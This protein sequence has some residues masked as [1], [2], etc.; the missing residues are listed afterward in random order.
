MTIV[1]ALVT[2]DRVGIISDSSVTLEGRCIGETSKTIALPA[3]RAL[4]AGAGSQWVLS[5]MMSHLLEP[6]P[7]GAD[8]GTVARVASGALRK[9]LP[10]MAGA[11]RTLAIVG[12]FFDGK[13]AAVLLRAPNFDPE[14]LR[15]GVLPIPDPNAAPADTPAAEPAVKPAAA[16]AESAPLAAPVPRFPWRHSWADTLTIALRFVDWQREAR[17]VPTGGPL[18]LVTIAHDGGIELRRLAVLDYLEAAS[19]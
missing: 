10:H 7:S 18:E 6:L 4:V 2:P 14:S 13:L 15:F 3:A 1:N 5:L 12:G 11:S 16:P 9:A 19:P 8:A 17:Q